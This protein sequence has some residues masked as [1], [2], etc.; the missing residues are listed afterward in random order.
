LGLLRA[1]LGSFEAVPFRP[2][3]AISH[4]CV[5]CRFGAVSGSLRV[6]LSRVRAVLGCLGL[7]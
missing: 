1:I 4:G 7:F 3:Q 6:V 2:F 5:S